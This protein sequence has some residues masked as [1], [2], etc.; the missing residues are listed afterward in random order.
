[1]RT[2]RDRHLRPEAKAPGFI[3]AISDTATISAMSVAGFSGASDTFPDTTRNLYTLGRYLVM[4]L[5]G[6]T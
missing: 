3:I 5:L 4:A 1:M 6:G 2:K